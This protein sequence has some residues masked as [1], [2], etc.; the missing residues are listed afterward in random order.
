MTTT[1]TSSPGRTARRGATRGRARPPAR[2]RAADGPGVL[3][4]PDR[5]LRRFATNPCRCEA[6]TTV[7]R[8]DEDGDLTCTRCGR[9]VAPRALWPSLGASTRAV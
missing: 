9:Q 8:R 6:G 4:P 1:V 2:S 5:P 3:A 7:H